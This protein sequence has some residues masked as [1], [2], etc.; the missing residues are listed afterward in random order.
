VIGS[1]SLGADFLGEGYV[2]GATGQ[3]IAVGQATSTALAQAVT[4]KK[5]R[6][7]GQAFETD[8]AQATAHSKARAT[9]KAFESDLA[10][11]VHPLTTNHVAQASETDSAF[12]ITH[13]RTVHVQIAIET[14]S[15]PSI[16]PVVTFKRYQTVHAHWERNTALP[17]HRIHKSSRVHRVSV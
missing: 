17:I 10:Q 4:I 6:A 16:I 15:V 3:T 8:A 1:Q 12:S 7:V 13:R 14:D 5:V 2:L 9:G 11:A